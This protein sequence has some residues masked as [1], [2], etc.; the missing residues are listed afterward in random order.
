MSPEEKRIAIA[1]WMGW[2]DLSYSTNWLTRPDGSKQFYHTIQTSWEE[3]VP[4]YVNDLNAIHEAESKLMEGRSSCKLFWDYCEYLREIVP[5]DFGTDTVIHA[6]AAQR[7]EALL[8]T[9][10]L[11]K[12]GA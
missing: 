1:G 12:D 7:C 2:K 6:T 10:G 11:W 9:L 3:F 8:K 4:D 5:A